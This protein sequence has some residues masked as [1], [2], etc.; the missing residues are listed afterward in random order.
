MRPYFAFKT[1]VSKARGMISSHRSGCGAASIVFDVCG[2]STVGW[3]M[4]LNKYPYVDT[5]GILKHFL[6][7]TWG[8][9]VSAPDGG[10]VPVSEVYS[11]DTDSS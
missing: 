8:R 5:Y 1:G 4:R 3:G 2:D 7:E 10:H 9:R 6:S 11:Q